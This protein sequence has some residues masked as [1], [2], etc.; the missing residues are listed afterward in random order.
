LSDNRVTFAS[1]IYVSPNVTQDKPAMDSLIEQE[2][3]KIKSLITKNTEFTVRIQATTKEQWDHFL[4]MSGLE[5]H[6]YPTTPPAILLVE[7]HING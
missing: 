7:A 1:W 5:P 6:D 2:C 3:N 4:S